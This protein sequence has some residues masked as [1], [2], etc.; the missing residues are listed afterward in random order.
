MKKIFMSLCLLATTFSVQAYFENSGSIHVGAYR[1]EGKFKILK[2]G[3]A[4]DQAGNVFTEGA[5]IRGG[6]GRSFLAKARFINLDMEGLNFQEADVSGADF[7]GTNLRATKL[8]KAK[9]RDA[10]FEKAHNLTAAQRNDLRKRGAR[11]Y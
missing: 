11:V 10:N 7:S 8:D 3:L 9:V 2:G 1:L 5:V 4:M 6:L